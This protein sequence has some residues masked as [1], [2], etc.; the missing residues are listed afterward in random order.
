MMYSKEELSLLLGMEGKSIRQVLYHQWLN[1]S[2]PAAIMHFIDYIEL[3]FTDQTKI[4]FHRPDEEE[5]ISPLT[6]VDLATL[7]A[8]LLKEFNGKLKY[9]SKDFS[10]TLLWKDFIGKPISA[11]LLDEEEPGLYTTEALVLEA[12]ETK[13]LIGLSMGEGLEAGPFGIVDEE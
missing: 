7:N 11:V 4:L 13:V 1:T 2:D 5:R 12:G 9:V 8:A 6:E 3:R 10:D